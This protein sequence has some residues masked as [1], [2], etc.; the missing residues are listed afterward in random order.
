MSS[1][2]QSVT[3]DSRD[4]LRSMLVSTVQRIRE[5]PLEDLR[6]PDKLHDLLF[7]AGVW[8][9]LKKD[10]RWLPT[11]FR[12][13]AGTGLRMHQSPIQLAPYLIFLSDKNIDSYIEIGTAFGGTFIFTVE[14]LNRFHPIRR[15]VAVDIDISQLLREYVNLNPVAKAWQGRS[16]CWPLQ[17][18]LGFKAKPFAYGLIDAKHQFATVRNDFLCLHLRKVDIIGFHDIDDHF[19]RPPHFAWKELNHFLSDE[20]HAYEFCKQYSNAIEAKRPIMGL[21]L[22]VRKDAYRLPDKR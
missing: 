3:E 19:V 21:G 13:F 7:S 20:Y 4:E 6:D 10:G 11:E 5:V 1:P 15:A 2:P 8:A 14:Y 16:D 12:H 9:G 22:M 18:K 17:T